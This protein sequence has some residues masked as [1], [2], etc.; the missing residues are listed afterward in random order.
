MKIGRS[1]SRHLASSEVTDR[2]A[3]CPV[4]TSDRPRPP[5]HRIQSDPD[6]FM[7][8]CGRCGACSASHMPRGEVL[9]AYYAG[10]YAGH[11]HAIRFA[12]QP[13]RFARHVLKAIGPAFGTRVRILDYG[14]GDGTLAVSIAAAIVE[15]R[16]EA[17]VDILLV[18][19][20]APVAVR[21]EQIQIR[22]RLPSEPLDERFDL[23]LA[24][25]VLE[26][27]PEVHDVFSALFAATET[28]GYFYAR[29]PY[30]IPFRNVLPNLD[31]TYPAHVHDMGSP[32]WNR[33]VETFGWN[34]RV[35]ASRPSVIESS[36][37]HEPLRTLAAAVLKAPA[38]LENWLSPRR[39]KSRLWHFVGGWEVLLQRR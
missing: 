27:V 12:G 29:T 17:R 20:P 19:F 4:C 16:P 35:V 30:A 31:V 32:F 2:T 8:R 24:S 25:G 9:G 1:Q 15:A 11:E 22:H 33:V 14:G 36:A 39:R 37:R 7:L 18:D 28:G 3:T 34:A 38:H 21:H 13:E 5:V 6:I 26:H 23:V 10:F